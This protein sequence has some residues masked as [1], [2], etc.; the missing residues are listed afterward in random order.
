MEQRRKLSNYFLAANNT[1]SNILGIFALFM[2]IVSLLLSYCIYLFT[3]FSISLSSMPGIS[4]SVVL[5][6]QTSLKYINIIFIITF[7]SIVVF[8]MA[9]ILIFAQRVGGPMISICK[10]IDQMKQGNYNIERK[11]RKNDELEPIMIK[12][13]ELARILQKGG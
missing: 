3:E 4:S 5:N 7:A 13:H 8:T 11:L 2:I 10:V 1:S 12:L 9:Y 6:L